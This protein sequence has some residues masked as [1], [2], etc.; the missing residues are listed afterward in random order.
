MNTDIIG[1][2]AF[3]PTDD[4]LLSYNIDPDTLPQN[5]LQAVDSIINPRVK[6]PDNGLPSVENGQRY[7]LVE[8]IGD[9]SITSLNYSVWG[10]LV[11]NANDIIQYN[12][13]TSKWTVD[14]D[15]QSFTIP[16]YVTNLTSGVQ[17]RYAEGSWMKSYEGWYDQGDYNIVI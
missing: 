13:S 8:S 11:A 10:D 17:Y 5:T 7:L 6:G 3:N 15:S 12:S 16:A 9:S 14:F 2:I 4:R 1:T